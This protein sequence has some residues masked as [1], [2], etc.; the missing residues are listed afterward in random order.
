MWRLRQKLQ[1]RE[2]LCG[3]GTS[4]IWTSS[5]C[6]PRAEHRLTHSE[7][8]KAFE[9]LEAA[10]ILTGQRLRFSSFGFEGANVQRSD[11]S[12]NL[13]DDKTHDAARLLSLRDVERGNIEPA[14]VASGAATLV[15]HL[16]VTASL[17]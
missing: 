17:R 7:M 12:G 16:A 13:G 15:A 4:K 11:E 14:A 5:V 10:T 3:Q 2:R 9:A 8:Y 1:M 6:A